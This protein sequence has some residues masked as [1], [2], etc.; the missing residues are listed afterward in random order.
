MSGDLARLPAM[1]GWVDEH[2]AFVKE[3]SKGNGAC[4][5]QRPAALR[6]AVLCAAIAG[7]TA[8]AAC[9]L[10]ARSGAELCSVPLPP[11]HAADCSDLPKGC[12]HQRCVSPRAA[13]TVGLFACLFANASFLTSPQVLLLPL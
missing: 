8:A 13:G 12:H 11:H 7:C 6:R 3:A 1:K 4:T 5:V 2:E 9:L 10:G